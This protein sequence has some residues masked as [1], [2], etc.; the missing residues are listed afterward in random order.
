MEILAFDSRRKIYFERSIL[1]GENK[2][3]KKEHDGVDVL[4]DKNLFARVYTGTLEG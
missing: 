3:K 2:K 1:L 4:A